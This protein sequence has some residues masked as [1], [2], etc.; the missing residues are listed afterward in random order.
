MLQLEAAAP[1][2][3]LCCHN[4]PRQARMRLKWPKL[5]C[6]SAPSPY[7]IAFD[8]LRNIAGSLHHPCD[9]VQQQLV[10]PNE[11]IGFG[12][13]KDGQNTLLVEAGS[14]SSSFANDST[15]A[16]ASAFLTPGN[17]KAALCK[18]FR[19]A[20]TYPAFFLS[21]APVRCSMFNLL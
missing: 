9:I 14:T 4:A 3:L 12:H 15:F 6:F 11:H 18:A 16:I 20:T 8:V 10:I 1:A 5:P 13:R 17:A 7:K 19:A 21:S 2:A